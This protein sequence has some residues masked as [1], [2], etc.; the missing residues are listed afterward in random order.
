MSR[1]SFFI[2]FRADALYHEIHRSLLKAFRQFY[3]RNSDMFQT[4]S[5]ST[6]LAVEMHMQVIVRLSIMTATTQFIAHSVATILNDMHQMVLLK[7]S[8]GAEHA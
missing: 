7:Q 1:Y 3:L 5:L 2:A 8:Q 4:V 6:L